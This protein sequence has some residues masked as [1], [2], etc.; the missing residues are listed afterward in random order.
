MR[1]IAPIATLTLSLVACG[2]S[3]STAPPPTPAEEPPVIVTDAAAPQRC[4]LPTV[5]LAGTTD[6]LC[7]PEHPLD[8]MLADARGAA[9]RGI[10]PSVLVVGPEME[11]ADR[12]NP[13][14]YARIAMEALL[15]TDAIIAHAAAMIRY[16]ATGEDRQVS[17]QAQMLMDRYGRGEL[18]TSSPDGAPSPWA[19]APGAALTQQEAETL[20]FY[21]ASARWV[22]LRDAERALAATPFEGTSDDLPGLM[23][24][25]DARRGAVEELKQIA[26][27][28]ALYGAPTW[29]APAEATVAVALQRLFDTLDAIPGPNRDVCLETTSQDTALCDQ[30]IARWE[31]ALATT[32][33][34][35]K[36]EAVN[37]FDAACSLSAR[38]NLHPDLRTFVASLLEDA[39][40][41]TSC[42][43]V[44][45]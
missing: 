35:I 37:H 5:F 4:A 15:P 30:T 27:E 22:E 40:P 16:A 13:N 24:A 17:R 29:V 20:A 42:G 14:A 32:F 21:A 25:I 7:V 3:S 43:A 23:A 1:W 8:P 45:P 6:A 12:A 36:L 28:I 11:G 9:L 26:E 2:G 34:P 10:G 19:T 31:A 39:F 38:R 41:E 18:R 44:T 33:E